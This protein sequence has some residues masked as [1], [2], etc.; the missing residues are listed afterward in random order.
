MQAHWTED[1]LELSFLTVSHTRTTQLSTAVHQIKRPEPLRGEL[2]FFLLAECVP[3]SQSLRLN[4][5]Y[6]RVLQKYR[7]RQKQA[8]SGF[9]FCL[10]LFFSRSFSKA[11]EK[12][13]R[14]T[15]VKS[16]RDRISKLTLLLTHWISEPALLWWTDKNSWPQENCTWEHIGLYSRLNSLSLNYMQ[17]RGRHYET[18]GWSARTALWTAQKSTPLG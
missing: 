5:R 1:Y 12:K 9:F 2:K 3:L 7:P 6:W 17:L 4:I 13:V 11:R 16:C 15:G 8:H 14:L 18:Q 10:F